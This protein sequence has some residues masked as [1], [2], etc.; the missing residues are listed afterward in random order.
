M[1]ASSLNDSDVDPDCIYVPQIFLEW[2]MVFVGVLGLVTA[3]VSI[4]HNCM[5][6]YTFNTSKVLRKRNLIYLKWISGCDVFFSLCYIAIMCVQVYTDFFESFRLFVWW[7]SYLR[8]AFTVSHITLS[9]ASFL[10]MAATI[11]R[12]LQSTG[13]NRSTQ[14]FR[15]L[16]THRGIVVSLCFLGSLIFRGTVFFEIKVVYN[17]KCEGFSSLGLAAVRVFSNPMV[18]V[19]WRFWV[20]KIVTVFLPFIVLAYFNARIVMNVRKTDRDQTVKA[21][22][23]F[24]TVG[25]R[26]EVTRLRSR[27][28]AVTR[29]LVLVVTCYLVANILD[30]IIA[31]WETIDLDSLMLDNAGVYAILADIS[32]FLPILACAL[33]LPIYAINDRQIRTEVRRKFNDLLSRLCGCCPAAECDARL[34]KKLYD[35]PQIE[36]ER[37]CPYSAKSSDATATPKLEIRA[38]GMGSLIMARASLSTKEVY[39]IEQFRDAIHV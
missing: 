12:Y 13:D 39:E 11:E 18:D 36:A 24:I 32:S 38:Y 8:T 28:R 16:A 33:R 23:L 29:M 7:H 15:L 2:K 19:V 3:V 25:T 1:E 21:L 27:L 4:V 20:R 26:G 34:R 37:L 9:A 6:F 5:L 10:L 22:V 35:V 14:L 30:V 31:F 17:H